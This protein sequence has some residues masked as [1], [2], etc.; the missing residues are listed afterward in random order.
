[1]I[2]G[3]QLLNQGT[4]RASNNLT[5]SAKNISNSGLMQAGERLSLLAV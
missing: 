5:A 1:L 4:L 3:G 2:S